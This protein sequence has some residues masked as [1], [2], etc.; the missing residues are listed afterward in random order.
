MLD[1]Y[2]TMQKDR[3][4]RILER[5]LRAPRITR[6]ELAE[7]LG[8]S[9][10]S[11]V[12]YTR[13]LMDLGF[14][15]QEG[16][17]ESTGG[18]RRAFLEFDPSVGVNLVILFHLS[19]LEGALVNPAG[20]VEQRVKLPLSGEETQSDYEAMLIQLIGDLE[21]RAENTGKEIFAS[22][23]AM[24]DHLDMDR[25][26]SHYYHRCPD[27]QDVDLKKLVQSK[28]NL[29]FFLIN[30]T[31]AA[32]LGEMYYGQG[33]G[34]SHFLT[35]WDTET[36]GM[37]LV[38]NDRIYLG[39]KGFVGEIG[40]VLAVPQ[41]ELCVCG[42]QGCL[43]TVAT[44]GYL[45]KR[46]REGVNSGVKSTLTSVHGDSS[47]TVQDIINASNDGDRFCCN[48]M[49]EL[50]GYMGHALA[51]VA[52]VLNPQR[53][54]LGGTVM[55]DNNFLLEN[56]QRIVATRAM[57]PICDDIEI[58]LSDQEDIPLKGISSYVLR[59]LFLQQDV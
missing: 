19:C 25:G 9:S 23:I 13:E 12:K 35:L 10:S 2:K 52:N 36:L 11:I 3:M 56:I 31:D 51:D 28:L 22:G 6:A 58:V 33:R 27:W 39:Q 29:P 46:S 50:A 55:R 37:G 59:Q 26:I 42:N 53:V 38:L 49:E 40:H 4:G 32:A 47:W 45:L 43:E 1:Q 57:K 54:I 20:Q 16:E 8:L 48:L 30:D 21:Q 5:I 14:L 41:G 15:R 34:Y 18:R 24:G 7:S 17:G 44:E